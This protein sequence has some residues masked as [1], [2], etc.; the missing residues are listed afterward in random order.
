M[1]SIRTSENEALRIQQQPTNG[2]PAGIPA[3]IQQPGLLTTLARLST[4]YQPEPDR[5][6][7]EKT[8]YDYPVLKAPVW[9]W[10]IIWYFFMGGLAGGCYVLATIASLFG[11]KEDRVVARVGYYVSLL[12][13]LPC[14]PC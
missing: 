10:E 14:P 11:S 12:A 7:Q 3:I 9:S 4:G 5:E 13:L 8:Y 2:K 6:L 1:D